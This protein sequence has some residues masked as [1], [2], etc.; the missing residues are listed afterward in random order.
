MTNALIHR[1]NFAAAVCARSGLNANLRDVLRMNTVHLLGSSAMIRIGVL[2]NPTVPLLSQRYVRK[3]RNAWIMNIVTRSRADA[4]L[5]EK[6]MSTKMRT[7]VTLI[8]RRLS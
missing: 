2:T 7:M 3:I 6:L 4:S 5:V 1:R 8:F